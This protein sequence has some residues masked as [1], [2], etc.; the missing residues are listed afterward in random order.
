LT[1]LDV[2]KMIYIRHTKQ[3]EDHILYIPYLTKTLKRAVAIVED[4]LREIEG[5]S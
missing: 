1:A 5:L 4:V 2:Q 3:K